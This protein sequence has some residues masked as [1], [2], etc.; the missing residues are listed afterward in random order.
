MWEK[1]G[2]VGGL[3]LG[4]LGLILLL[5]PLFFVFRE[6]MGGFSIIVVAISLLGLVC[7]LGWFI[8]DTIY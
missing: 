4:A 8:V 6:I 5:G 1:Q 7:F 2:N 3:I